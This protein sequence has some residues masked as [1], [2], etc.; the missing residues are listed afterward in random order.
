MGVGAGKFLISTLL[1]V[2]IES[3]NPLLLVPAKLREHTKKEIEK[4]R[5]HW[6]IPDIYVESYEMLS[7][8][9]S[10]TFLEEL[11]P[12]DIIMDE[13]HHLKN[14]RSA[15]WRKFERYLK[16]HPQVR[17]YMMSGSFM[18]KSIKDMAH[19]MKYALGANS[20]LPS[21]YIDLE[22]WALALDAD[23]D[24]WFRPPPGV[25]TEFSGGKE[26]LESVR[27][28]V[29]DRIAS[30]PGVVMSTTSA[31]DKPLNIYEFALDLPPKID[32]YLKQLR[33][34]WETPGGDEID[35]GMSLWRHTRE[36]CVGFYYKWDPPPPDYWLEARRAWFG[37]VRK[38][39]ASYKIANG[40]HLDS[41]LQVAQ[42]VQYLSAEAQ[43]L[44]KAWVEVRDDYQIESV[45]VWMDR[46][47]I[48]AA[49]DWAI[50][51]NGIVWV[52]HTAVGES[53]EKIPYFGAGDHRIDTHKGPCAASMKAHGTGKNL[54]QW[55]DALVLTPP[56]SAL[57]WEQV[58]GRLHRSGQEADEVNYHVVVNAEET[59]EAFFKAKS[60][61]EAIEA[62]T[63]NQQKL[64]M[65][66]IAIH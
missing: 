33:E 61:A 40:V 5:K 16:A 29:R 39:L 7:S 12:D 8:A 1:P 14:K 66:T 56:S 44:H 3:K 21:S 38:I 42:N 43:D 13:A 46:F 53:F 32:H 54:I 18:N 55:S 59:K 45:P 41:P 23:V 30:A 24:P 10:G 35:S 64:N 48:D 28:G 2:L 52:S 60:K 51:N 25:L 26:D 9:K 6:K 34:T 49:E 57:E 36:L 27:H 19:L 58:L 4:Q 17:L 62:K 37:K 65:A 20:P 50:K 22:K 31:F 63:G 11:A 15:R 47:A